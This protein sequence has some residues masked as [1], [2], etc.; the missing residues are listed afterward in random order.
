M[1]AARFHNKGDIRVEEVDEPKLTEGKVHVDVEWCGICGSDLH[2]FI[3][4]PM[5]L[6]T[7]PHVSSGECIPLAIG[8]ELCGRV[9]NPPPGS[10]LKDGEAVMVDPRIWC[11]SCLACQGGIYHCCQE[12]GYVGGSISGGFGERV[13]IE[14]DH[15]YPLGPNIPLEYAAVIEPLA[16]VHHAVKETGIKDWTD[17]TAL[18]LGGGPIGFALLIDLKAHGAT[19]III[20]EPTVTRREQVSEYAS[21]VVNPINEKVGDK[22]REITGGR[23]VDVVFDCAGVPAGLEAGFDA[24]RVEGMYMNVAVWEVSGLDLD[25][26]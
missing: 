13:A 4:G 1:R 24:L 2:E 9:R 7:K 22:C 19:N 6:P 8:H 18:V 14:E 10:R 3:L 25:P 23:G 12:I 21:A 5:F 20:S 26:D 16:V 11:G 17:K 15:L